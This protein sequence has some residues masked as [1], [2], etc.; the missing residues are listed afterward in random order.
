MILP[1]INFQEDLTIMS[2]FYPFE[3]RGLENAGKELSYFIDSVM[4]DY[5]NITLIGHS[6]CG[7]CFANAAKWIKCKNL[8]IVTISAPF[9]GTIMA[10]KEEMFRLFWFRKLYTY[11]YCFRMSPKK[12]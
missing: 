8:K 7:V 1:N 12:P 3:S 11:Q 10:N 2:I 4:Q 5:D 9:L 6:K